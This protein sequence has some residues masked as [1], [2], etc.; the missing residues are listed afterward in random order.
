MT[1]KFTHQPFYL[2]TAFKKHKNPLLFSVS[3]TG[4]DFY[5]TV[6]ILRNAM[7]FLIQPHFIGNHR[8][9]FRVGR[10]TAQVM[11]RIS[12]IAV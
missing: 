6:L 12:K 8:D 7:A 1:K 5:F 2:Y 11:N 10:L 4:E 9:K 3:K